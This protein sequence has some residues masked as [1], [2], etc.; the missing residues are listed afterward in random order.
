[1]YCRASDHDTYECPTLL[2]KIQEKRNKN[3]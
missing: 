3:N 2:R 1:M